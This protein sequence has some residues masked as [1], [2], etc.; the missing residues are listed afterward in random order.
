MISAKKTG[1]NPSQN[2]FKITLKIF[3]FSDLPHFTIL[4]FVESMIRGLGCGIEKKSGTGINIYD[5][6]H[7][8]CK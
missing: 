5:P 8:S 6:Q 4:L 2:N 3:R 7:C 1:E